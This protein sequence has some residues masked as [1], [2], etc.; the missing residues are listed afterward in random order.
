MP[1][2]QKRYVS[3]KLLLSCLLKIVLS[4]EHDGKVRGT[5]D[6]YF[7]LIEVRKINI[8]QHYGSY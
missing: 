5:L 3:P 2:C 1:G 7:S 4:A 8:L 6:I